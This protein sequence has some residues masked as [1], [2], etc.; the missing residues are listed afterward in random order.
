GVGPFNTDTTLIYSKVFTNTGSAYNPTTGIFTATVRGVYC[1]RFTAIELRN[2]Q[3]MAV[4]LYHNDKRL[5]YSNDQDDGAGGGGV[6]YMRLP[7]GQGLYDSNN[8]HNT[9][10][11]FLLCP[12]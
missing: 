8:N 2:D 7:S 9:F 11:G 4:Y 12:V 6:V 1:I 5:M 10:S 3:W